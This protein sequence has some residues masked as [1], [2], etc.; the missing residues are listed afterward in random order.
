MPYPLEEGKLTNHINTKYDDLKR[1]KTQRCKHMALGKIV[2]DTVTG[3]RT[4]ICY[5]LL[6]DRVI[7]KKLN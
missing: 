7:E 5:D 6:N 4:L 2:T 1:F 3:N